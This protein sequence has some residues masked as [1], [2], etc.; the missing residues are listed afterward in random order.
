MQ[1]N[2]RTVTASIGE[3]DWKGAALAVATSLHTDLSS[4]VAG[5]GGRNTRLHLHFHPRA[6]CLYHD[7]TNPEYLVF[8]I[9]ESLLCSRHFLGELHLL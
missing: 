2:A 7:N 6:H 4:G 1:G 5:L 9:A 3:S 8:L